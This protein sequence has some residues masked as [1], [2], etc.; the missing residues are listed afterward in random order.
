MILKPSE[1]APLS[2][3]LFAEMIHDTGFP[4]GVFN[5]VNGD[6]VGVGSQLSGHPDV[7]MVS[8]TGSTR[9]G[10]L[11]TKNSADTIKR[12]CLELGGK[13]A[14]VIFDDVDIDDA[15]E[16][17]VGA[18]TFHTG[19]VCCDATRWLIQKNIYDDF[20]NA[21]TE[22]LKA[23]NIGHQMDDEAQMGPVVSETQRKRVLDYLE[24]GVAEGAETLLEGG[25]AEVSGRNGHYVKPALLAGSLDNVAARE[26]IF[27][28]V[29]YC[30]PFSIEAEG[31]QLAN[32]TDYGLANSV[33]SSD[34]AKCHRVAE[35]FE[36]G[37]GWIN[38]HNVVVHGVPY[39]GVKKSGMGGG[40][41]SLETLL[42]YYRNISVI[43]PL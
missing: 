15:A 5:L 22:R 1:I 11:I 29:A 10:R 42:D 43:R 3:M 39:A 33:W 13:G 17:L 23:V 38:S 16:K 7:D 20:I 28:P 2:G 4:P 30:A 32:D 6:G 21:A 27:G 36:T 8:F 26:E 12:V 40:V 25:P 37:N 24:K 19:Q 31:V 35:A 34:L 14:A 9:A 18:I 41:V